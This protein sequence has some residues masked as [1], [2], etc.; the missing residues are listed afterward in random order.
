M[1]EI[2]DS[3]VMAV[4]DRNSPNDTA[5]VEFSGVVVEGTVIVIDGLRRA[6]GRRPAVALGKEL[7][8]SRAIVHT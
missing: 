7:R 8:K 4:S 5:R 3:K 2:T 1:I 6:V